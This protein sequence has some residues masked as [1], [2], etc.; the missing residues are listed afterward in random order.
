M[1]LMSASAAHRHSPR[2]LGWRTTGSTAAASIA[3]AVAALAIGLRFSNADT[4]LGPIMST[5]QLTFYYWGQNRLANLIPAI[6]WVVQD[7]AANFYLQ[8]VLIACCT[9][10]LLVFLAI[11][12]LR[13]LRV[14]NLAA[15]PVIVLVAGAMTI[16]VYGRFTT[17]VLVVEQ[18]YAVAFLMTLA[19]G[20]AIASTRASLRV[21]GFLLVIGAIIL[22]PSVVLITPVVAAAIVSLRRRRSAALLGAA[23]VVGTLLSVA[24]SSTLG[25]PVGEPGTYSDFSIGRSFANLD[26]VILHI[27]QA[28]HIDRALVVLALGLVAVVVRR[29]SLPR[30][31]HVTTLG[32]LVFVVSWVV[33][34]SGSRWVE[35][36]LLHFRYFFP[37]MLLIHYCA[38]AAVAVVV[39]TVPRPLWLTSQRATLGA[40]I[41]SI[42]AT[43]VA[44]TF[45]PRIDEL[46]AVRATAEAADSAA[47]G[48]IALIAG[49]YW[50][51]WP[52]V[53]NL[54]ADGRTS[55]GLAERGEVMRDELMRYVRNRV[56]S[57]L[58]LRVLCVDVGVTTC[59]SRLDDVS[60][61][62]WRL[63]GAASTEPLV[64]NVVP[65]VDQSANP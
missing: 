29:R 50:M 56:E 27:R 14:D 2:N 60:R 40:G 41:I 7:P 42:A 11:T 62:Q 43:A 12:H 65:I 21:G 57:D 13:A 32:A 10:G 16:A 48:D 26:E 58:P 55:F 22:N 25:V 61:Q 15:L 52:V 47:A 63:L 45:V 51:V 59:L 19:G 39:T 64:L 44:A 37:L 4:L 3:V 33:L 35:I 36:N 31:H 34:F 54:Q 9:S 49:S 38:T 30:W 18:H 23:A 6:A 8:V 17:Y 1:G 24:A 53:F 28:I 46:D 20:A 5:N